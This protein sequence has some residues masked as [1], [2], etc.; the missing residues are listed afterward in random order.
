MAQRECIFV[1]SIILNGV[2]RAPPLNLS[3][4]SDRESELL[5]SNQNDARAIAHQCLKGPY[6]EPLQMYVDLSSGWFTR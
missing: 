4:S 1:L 2:A 6:N 5:H 3:P